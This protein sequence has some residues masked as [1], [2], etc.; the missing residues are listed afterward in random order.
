[1]S[2]DHHNSDSHEV[3]EITESIKKGRELALIGNYEDAETYYLSAI[4][5]LKKHQQVTGSNQAGN[6]DM[7]TKEYELVSSLRATLASFKEEGAKKR[8]D[9]PV[10]E[11]MNR[12]PVRPPV[13]VTS[14]PSEDEVRPVAT[15]PT[16]SDEKKRHSQQHQP[17]F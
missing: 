11:P 5:T 6:V 17:H 10:R 9:T 14:K 1:M 15:H 12:P 8:D 2:T 13:H 16:H 4:S 7:L 3:S